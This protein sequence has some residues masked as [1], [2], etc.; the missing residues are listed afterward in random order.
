MNALP[1][2]ERRGLIAKL[3]NDE[4]R[5][6]S[7]AWRFWAHDMQ[8]PP[9]GR[10]RVWLFLGGR[11]AGKTR[12]GAEW[13]A[14]G[15]RN[16]RMRRIGLIGA[17]FADARAVMVEG[18]SGL[19]SVSRGASFE[20]SN[21]RILW[22]SGAVA[23]VV[24]AEEPDGVR[25][26]QF[27]A[28][29]ADEFAKWRDP[30][31]SLDMAMM[32][33]RLGKDPRMAVTTTPRNIAALKKLIATS[34]ARMTR[35]TT[36]DNADNLAPTF[37]AG[38]TLRYAGTRLGRQEL[39]AELIEDND[40]AMWRRDW[41]EKARVRTVPPLVRLVVA[42]DPP[43]SVAGD[44]CGIVAAGL[45]QDG[46][47]YVTGDYSAAG[48]TAAGWAGR[49]ADAYE[50]THA[51][52]VV[53]E[54]N[55]GGD[56][57]KQVLLDVLPNVAVRL[58]HATR[59]KCTR[60]APAAALY[61]QGRVHHA[62]VFAELEDQLCQFDGTGKSPDRLDALVWALADLFPAKRARPKVR[63]V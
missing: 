45:A 58:V 54:A 25:G 6:L 31:A 12:A 16:R 62:G 5:L 14:G 60:A 20:P 15:V 57:V 39:E 13:V 51:D 59:D 17:T 2:C 44:E 23:T 30:Q 48:L 24:S 41:I 42:V 56:M 27:D 1:P 43:A 10:W 63:T 28:V 49:V 61:E 35:G 9:A 22:P 3:S 36:S 19:L 40:A 37:L 38:L 18:E 52:L 4:A 34:D 53:A 50:Q 8:L 55:Q 26:H 32:A 29:W 21:R 47:A 33:L 46:A 7:G 11:G